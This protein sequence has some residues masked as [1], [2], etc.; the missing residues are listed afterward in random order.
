MSITDGTPT[1]ESEVRQASFEDSSASS[2]VGQTEESFWES[3]SPTKLTQSAKKSYYQA[4]GTGP[5]PDLA[6][7]LYAE[8]EA[9]YKAAISAPPEMRRSMLLE[10]ASKYAQAAKR[11]PD[12]ALEHDGFYMAGESYFFADAYPQ[13]NEMYEKMIKKYPGTKHMDTI[14]ARRYAI[15]QYWLEMTNDKPESV[16]AVNYTN[17]KKPWRDTRGHALRLYDKIRIDD[18]TGKLADDAT[19]AAGNAYFV[20]GDY[21]KADEYY[22][23]LRKAFPGSEHQFKAHFLGLKTKLLCYQGSEYSGAA[24]DD[25][26]KIIQQMR[27]QFP[28]ES[29]EEREFLTRAWA[30]VRFKK[31]QREWD[32]AQYFV[33]RAEYGAARLYQETLVK[34]YEDTPFAKQA[35]EQ[36]T[37]QRDLPAEPPKRLEWLVELFPRE[38]PAKPLFYN[39]S[40]AP[41]K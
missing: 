14:D 36:L 5:R 8:A 6:R 13:S 35:Q 28:R 18:P 24:L 7:F 16:F 22:G 23:D 19:L 31:A 25:A 34:D 17:A 2:D 37:K 33:R 41:K 27:K 20:S 29:E 4:T 38:K 21:F 11:W 12:S 15:A 10:A 40:P 3:F 1:G 26:E 9:K 32:T 30:E 39:D